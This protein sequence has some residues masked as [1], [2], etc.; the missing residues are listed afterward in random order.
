MVE[1]SLLLLQDKPSAS[2]AHQTA[3]SKPKDK[4]KINKLKVCTLYNV[5]WFEF[6]ENSL[7]INEKKKKNNEQ[8]LVPKKL[9]EDVLIQLLFCQL[10]LVSMSEFDLRSGQTS[11]LESQYPHL[12][13]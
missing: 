4:D 7:S 11:V 9:N 2:S 12:P 10:K 8:L 5:Q 13:C 1:N 6:A 3:D